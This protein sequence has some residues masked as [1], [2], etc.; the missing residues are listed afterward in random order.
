MTGRIPLIPALMPGSRL[1]QVGWFVALGLCALA[2]VALSFRVN[3]VKSEVRL[4]ERRIIAL[5]NQKRE[6]EIEFQTRASQRQ[7]A[8]WNRIEFGYR[9][10]QPGQYLD[11][12]RQLASLGQPRGEDAPA[13]IRVARAA[14]PVEEAGALSFVTDFL[15][16]DSAS[17][18]ANG[19]NVTS[20]AV[21]AGTDMVEEE[22][23]EIGVD[24]GQRLVEQP[25]FAGQAVADVAESAGVDE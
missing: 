3:A 4:A 11:S 6:L 23:V 20:A 18:S 25:N 14:S 9:A 10:P 12:T 13:P 7:L 16:S 24:I 5:E 2:F 21:Q 1:R 17:E 15:P 19:A 22:L 8:N